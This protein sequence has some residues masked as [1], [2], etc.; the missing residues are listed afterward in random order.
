[1]NS[2]YLRYGRPYVS[3]GILWRNDILLEIVPVL[4]ESKR[5]S[6]VSINLESCTILLCS[7]YMPG[8]AKLHL[9]DTRSDV[10]QTLA[11]LTDSSTYVFII[12]GGDFNCCLTDR[13]KNSV[14]EISQFMENE[15][16]FC[17][18]DLSHSHNIKYTF[19]SKANKSQSFIDHFFLSQ[20]LENC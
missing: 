9:V 3:C 8:C 17:V 2:S 18:S 19:E 14:K 20:N 5:I 13:T 11:H 15:N 16:L 1:M 7:V 10:T 12:I 4:T 6:A